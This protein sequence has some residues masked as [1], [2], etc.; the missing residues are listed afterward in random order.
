[1][2][3]LKPSNRTVA[4]Y[5]PTDAPDRAEIPALSSVAAMVADYKGKAAVQAGEAFDAS[6]RNIDARTT[7]A[8]LPNGAQLT[9]LPKQT[10]GKQ[11]YVAAPDESIAE[12]TAATL[13]DVRSFHAQF[14]GASFADI[15]V[16]G[17][18]DP[19]AVAA[20][21]TRLFGDWKNPQPFARIVR[22][23]A[24]QDSTSI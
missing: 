3:Y 21:A 10:R 16:V 15:A 23:Y 24:P 20:A 11:L 9:P 18:F 6:P 1:S 17:D 22:T 7:H 2:T 12:L 8:V 4:V 13:A 14:Y 5:L 19:T